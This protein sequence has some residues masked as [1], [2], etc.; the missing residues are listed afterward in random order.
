[1]RSLLADEGRAEFTMAGHYAGCARSLPEI[2]HGKPVSGILALHV[3]EGS[4]VVRVFVV[5]EGSLPSRRRRVH[6]EV[7]DDSEHLEVGQRP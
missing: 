1:M 6:D 5:A 2:G 3:L 4:E 7:S